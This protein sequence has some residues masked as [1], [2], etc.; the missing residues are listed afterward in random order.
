MKKKKGFIFLESVIALVVVALSLT[1]FLRSYTRIVNL[2]K[3]NEVYDNVSDKYLLYAIT[4]FGAS[5]SNNMNMRCPANQSF[6]ASRDEVWNLKR[7]GN[8]KDKISDESTHCWA[9]NF[10]K[11]PRE[12]RQRL[13]DN[14]GLVYF[15]YINT[16]VSTLL[17]DNA[18]Y[19]FDNGTL[20][21]IQT[22]SRNNKYA[23]GVFKRSNKS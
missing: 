12:D 4:N 17:T 21:Y 16:T 5:G 19:Y 1:A 3:Q 7:S 2:S 6:G 9:G 13:F 20:D 22:L 23:V 14:L 15:Y 10:F 8:T 18:T 11:N